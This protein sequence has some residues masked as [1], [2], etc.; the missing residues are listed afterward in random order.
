MTAVMRFGP[1]FR[2]EDHEGVA[3]LSNPT[4][5]AL[6]SD[7]NR[8]TGVEVVATLSGKG[9]CSIKSTHVVLAAGAIENARYSKLRSTGFTLRADSEQTRRA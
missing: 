7:A 1:D 4:E 2:T 6:N 8:V 3:V 9:R 5:C